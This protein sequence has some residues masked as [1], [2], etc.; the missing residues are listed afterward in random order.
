[1]WPAIVDTHMHFACVQVPLSLS[2]DCR[3]SIWNGKCVK[4]KSSLFLWSCLD[5]LTYDFATRYIR[6]GDPKRFVHTSI[7]EPLSQFQYHRSAWSSWE[8]ISQGEFPFVRCVKNK[9]IIPDLS[10]STHHC[11]AKLGTLQRKVTLVGCRGD[12]NSRGQKAVPRGA[13][14]LQG[15]K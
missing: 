1:M 4:H 8:Q 14:D 2:F 7:I 13:S 15:Y 10:Q 6:Q 11:I 3:I 9:V 5:F 12:P